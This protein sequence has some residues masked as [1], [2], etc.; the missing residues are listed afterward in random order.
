MEEREE[1]MT[2]S[3]QE[4]GDVLLSLEGDGLSFHTFEDIGR[5]TIFPDNMFK[6]MFPS[7]AFGRFEADEY[8]INKVWGTMTREEGLRLT[9]ELSKL[10]LPS[11]RSVN[12]KNIVDIGSNTE[13]KKQV[14]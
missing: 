14:I 3:R 10:T 4:M 13:I 11:E 5:Y 8:N 12:Y 7:K 2:I 6:R 1:Q 9:N